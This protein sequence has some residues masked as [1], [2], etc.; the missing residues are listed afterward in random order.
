MKL[1]LIFII[2]ILPIGCFYSQLEATNRLA[3]FYSPVVNNLENINKSYSVL[4]HENINIDFKKEYRPEFGVR[5]SKKFGKIN[6]G[7]GSSNQGVSYTYLIKIKQKPFPSISQSYYIQERSIDLKTQTLELSVG[8]WLFKR[9]KTS[10]ILKYNYIYR[11]KAPFTLNKDN[12]GFGWASFSN[13]QIIDEFSVDVTEKR[14][15]FRSFI[16]PE[17]NFQTPIG[18][19]LFLYYG[20]KFKFWNTDD[21]FSIKVK[22]FYGAGGST[23]PLHSSVIN[24]RHLSIYFGLLYDINLERKIKH[25]N[26]PIN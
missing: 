18:K 19:S 11:T 6:L 8:L 16:T 14:E 12:Y 15:D 2:N 24:N 23:N 20:A 21:V 1:I 25:Q 10:F 5:Y 3:L 4:S 13:G 9:L 22:G 26:K 17:F 7:L